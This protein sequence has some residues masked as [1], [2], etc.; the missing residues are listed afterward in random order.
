MDQDRRFTYMTPS[1]SNILGY[2]PEEAL[3]LTRDQI[4][5]PS[6]LADGTAAHDHLLELEE[7]GR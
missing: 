5:P 1:V 3:A 2:S 7:T 6:S 4:L